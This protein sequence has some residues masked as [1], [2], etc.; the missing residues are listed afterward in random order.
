MLADGLRDQGQVAIMAAPAA[1]SLDAGPM[2]LAELAGGLKDAG[3]VNG[4]SDILR[5][6]TVPLAEKIKRVRQWIINSSDSVVLLLDEP[7]AWPDRFEQTQHFADHARLVVQELVHDIPCRRVLTGEAPEGMSFRVREPVGASSEPQVFLTDSDA[8]GELAQVAG[9]LLEGAGGQLGELSPLQLRLVV[10]LAYVTSVDEARDVLALGTRS[11]RALSRRLLKALKDHGGYKDL[12]RAW[13]RLAHI[14]RPLAEELIGSEI[15]GKLSKRSLALLRNCLLY[16]VDESYL[17][18][19][20]LRED[21]RAIDPKSEREDY[22]QFAQLCRYYRGLRNAAEKRDCGDALPAALDSFYYA[23]RA[24]DPDLLD[25]DPYFVDQLDI[26]GK[27]LSY[28]LHRYEEAAEVFDQAVRMDGSDDYAHHYLAYNLD[29]L[30]REPERVE[31]HYRGAIELNSTHPWWRARLVQFLLTRGRT[32]AARNEWDRSLDELGAGE[33]TDDV[34]FYETLHGW[35][36]DVALRRAQLPFADSVLAEVPP[37]VRTRSAQIT[38]LI[39]RLRALQLAQTDGAYVPASY[40]EKDWWKKGPFLLSRRIAEPQDMRIRRWLAGRVERVDDHQIELR[41]REI[42]PT[43]S[44]PPPA[45]TL[46]L[47]TSKFDTLTRDEQASELEPGR[48]VEVGLYSDEK[49]EQMRQLIR[50]HAVREWSDEALPAQTGAGDR[51][52]RSHGTG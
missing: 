27:T 10:A 28:E 4:Q 41:V 50:V 43:I 35:V 33:R 1:H 17:L 39:H 24:G 7:S 46:D 2:A 13:R 34:G 12:L 8:W 44:E 30:G 20:T 6:G 48:F 18:H 37:S 36:A 42:D 29:R 45:S 26:L 3:C 19:E 21:A 16:E 15:T 52:L 5:D 23:A 22:E 40:L 31:G 11:R 51:Y 38:A 47:S 32:T 9:Y 49:G 14:R 25:R